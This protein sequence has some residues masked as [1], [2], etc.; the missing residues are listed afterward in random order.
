MGSAG[1]SP[2][3]VGDPP[4]GTV[5]C[6]LAKLASPSIWIVALIPS[7][8]SPA[9]PRRL[10]AGGDGTGESPML[11]RNGDRAWMLDASAHFTPTR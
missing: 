5:E 7:G 1:D 11:P 2:A 10:R 8:E 9:P 3:P 6:I 4:T